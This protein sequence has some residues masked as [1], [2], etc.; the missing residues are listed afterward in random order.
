MGHLGVEPERIV[1]DLFGLDTYD[2]C[3][4]AHDVY[5]VRRALLVAQSYHLPRAVALCRSLGVDSDGVE[6]GC[7][8][9]RQT[10]LTKAALRELPA[11]WKAALDTWRD[12]PP[13]TVSPPDPAL[14]TAAVR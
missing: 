5:G 11:A 13:A 14:S 10:T 3:R 6:A 1:A 8:G 12:R 9:C 2:T 7:R 4:R